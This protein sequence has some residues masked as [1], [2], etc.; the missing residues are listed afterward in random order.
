MF[1]SLS[2]FGE[3]TACASGPPVFLEIRTPLAREP[4]FHCSFDEPGYFTNAF[5]AFGKSKME[6]ASGS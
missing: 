4:E 5:T 2:C 3:L 1:N 6:S